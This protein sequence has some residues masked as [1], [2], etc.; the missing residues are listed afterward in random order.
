MSV[1]VPAGF[2]CSL[3]KGSEEVP[4]TEL[5][6]VMDALLA[7]QEGLSMGQEGSQRDDAVRLAGG[8]KDRKNCSTCSKQLFN[9]SISM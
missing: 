7:A 6:T 5:A 1:G 2:S 3:F 9:I 4:F 8:A